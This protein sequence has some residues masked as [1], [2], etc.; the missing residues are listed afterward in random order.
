MN[1][2]GKIELT[3]YMGDYVKNKLAYCGRNVRL[4]PLCKI[5][6][7]EFCKIDDESKILDFTFIDGK[8]VSIGKYSIITWHC[9]IE[10]R[11]K[12][13]IGDRCFIGPGTKILSSTY[14]FHGLFTCEFLPDSCHDTEWGDVIINDD[15]Y[16]GANSVIM[17]GVTIGEGAIVGSNAFV[18]KDLDPWGIYVGSPV[19]KVGERKKP[20]DELRSIV[21]NEFDW[22]RH[23]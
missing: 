23:F 6:N 22:S 5:I 19:R 9:L 1:N 12:T 15:A 2:I 18:N 13:I 11:M 21:E 7:P 4:Y 14:K 17:P 10:G 8:E 20:S 3:E 16:I